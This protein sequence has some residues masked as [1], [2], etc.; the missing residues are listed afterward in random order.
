M[1][2]DLD[3]DHSKG[4]VAETRSEATSEGIAPASKTPLDFD[5]DIKP[6]SSNK[7][8]VETRRIP[9]NKARHRQV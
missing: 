4:R 2:F 7:L 1:L 8:A 3:K 9:P 5:P 6:P